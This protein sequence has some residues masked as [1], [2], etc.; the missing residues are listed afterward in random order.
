MSGPMR[1]S[2]PSSTPKLPKLVTRWLLRRDSLRAIVYL[3]LIALLLAI[4]RDARPTVRTLTAYGVAL[5]AFQPLMCFVLSPLV[6][7]ISAVL[8]VVMRPRHRT[9]YPC[10]VCGYDVRE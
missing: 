4:T 9:E 5:L 8:S 7:L 1:N 6:W 10:P 3:I 2:D